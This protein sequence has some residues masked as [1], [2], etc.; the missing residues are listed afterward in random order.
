VSFICFA[1]VS[2]IW[3]LYRPTYVLPRAHC[4]VLVATPSEKYVNLYFFQCLYLCSLNEH[5]L[6]INLSTNQHIC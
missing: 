4:L 3:F 1:K 5:R 6:Q 2:F